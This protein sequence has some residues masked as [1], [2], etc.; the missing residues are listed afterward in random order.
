METRR[1]FILCRG[2]FLCLHDIKN[3]EHM[4]ITQSKN[5]GVILLKNVVKKN[6]EKPLI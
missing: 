6:Y 4:L 5:Y 3:M 2:S 1:L